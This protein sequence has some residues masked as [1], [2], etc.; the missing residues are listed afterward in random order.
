MEWIPE[1]DSPS[2]S[3]PG[4]LNQKRSS[5]EHNTRMRRRPKMKREKRGPRRMI[6][7][8]IT[9][10]L[11][12]SDEEGVQLQT[13]EMSKRASLEARGRVEP[14][15]LG[16]IMTREQI[17]SQSMGC[18]DSSSNLEAVSLTIPAQLLETLER[19]ATCKDGREAKSAFV[20]RCHATFPPRSGP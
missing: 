13:G 9:R 1:M 18:V 15:R 16:H 7:I 14:P 17:S 4:H 6:A 10:K 8:Q 12:P 11:L 19:D 5:P 3:G 2:R 20:W